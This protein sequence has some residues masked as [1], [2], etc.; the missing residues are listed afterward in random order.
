[1]ARRAHSA[2]RMEAGVVQ[3]LGEVLN[4]IL[5]Q[6]L[7]EARGRDQ[8]Q[9]PSFDGTGDV[10]FFISQFED[11]AQANHWNN[12][13]TRIHLRAALKDTA[14]ACGQAED[15]EQIFTAL[16]A[17]FG[18]TGREAKA[19]LAA[20]RRE[21]HTTLQEHA[22]EVDR[23]VGLAYEE[24]PRHNRQDMKLDIFQT[25]LSNPYLQ[26]HLLAIQPRTLEEAVRAGNEF[27]QIRTFQTNSSIRQVEEGET[28]DCTR[29]VEDPLQALLKAVAK[30]TEEVN[31]L[32]MAPQQNSR[33]STTFS[34]SNL[35]CF[36]CDKSGHLRRDCLTKPWPARQSGNEAGP[37]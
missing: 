37:Q 22:A 27:L 15:V 18:L 32:K 31:T 13:S 29:Q 17:R 19:R 24:L 2:D 6:P 7:V 16:R 20:L 23:L 25:S 5:Q 28:E 3:Q 14:A 10:G 35:R 30:L 36:G 21:K 34:S 26:R 4:R 8:F 33:S 9:A 12:A 1:M 11:I